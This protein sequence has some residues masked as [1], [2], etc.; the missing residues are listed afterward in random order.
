MYSSTV[1]A[2]RQEQLERYVGK[3]LPSGRLERIPVETCHSLRRLLDLVWDP[4]K[5]CLRRS[6]S[7]DEEAFIANERLLTKIDW[8]YWC[9]RYC[10]INWEGQQLRPMFPLWESQELI[11]AEVA[12]VEEEHWR[13]AHPDG[14]LFNCLKG[15]QLG[16]SSMAQSFLAH[17]A[18]T[19]TH[20]RTL[21]AS[22][23]PQNSGS[24]GIFGMLEL[25]VKE[26]PW[27][28][29]PKEDFHTK[30]RHIMWA[31]GSRVIVESGKSMKG[32]LQ[33]E[34]GEKG[35][36]GRSKTY[37]A[38]HLS[39]IST[40][41]RPE[42]INSS[43]LPAIPRTPRTLCIRESTAMGR[44]DYWHTEWR[45]A[46]QN[47]DPRFFNIFIPWYAEV[48]KYWLPCPPGWTP[49]TDTLQFAKRAGEHGPRYMHRAVALTKEQLYWYEITK[50]S[51]EMDDQ[52]YR[53]LSEY[54]SEPE[55]A[56]QY[57]GRS[58]FSAATID[59]LEKQTRPLLDVWTVRPHAELQADKEQL[60][61]ELQRHQAQVEQEAR[62]RKI[63]DEQI[64]LNTNEPQI[65]RIEPPIVEEAR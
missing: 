10:W 46:A 19:H 54:P 40:W 12:R 50:A 29:K 49:S 57:S 38:A 3:A 34:G 8:R 47:K 35:Q 13:T 4:D 65:L 61:A 31:N 5:Q 58:I 60:L 52:L 64:V 11:L 39:E 22:D 17:R 44:N 55:E 63:R 62:E 9:E 33:E 59:R 41:E 21:I 7:Q 43:L 53:F 37:S 45:K 2:A 14:I 23:V 48:S 36:L 20:V 24:E 25:V 30:H 28:L 15:R 16:A 26:L 27:W 56:F 6:L 1:V 18:T 42:Q 51:F 32:G